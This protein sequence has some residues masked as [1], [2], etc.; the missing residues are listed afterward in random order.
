MKIVII[1]AGPAG[2]MG[3][4]KAAENEKNE[5]VLLEKMNSVRKETFNYG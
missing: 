3:A 1:G 4:I 2:M 5:V